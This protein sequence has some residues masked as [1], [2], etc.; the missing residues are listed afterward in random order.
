M[1]NIKRA[2]VTGA[3]GVVGTALVKELISRSIETLVLTRKDGRTE[4]IP[5]D[6]NVKIELCS[7]EEL[8][9][10]DIPNE[11]Y[12]VFFHLGWS[13]TYGKDRN[14]LAKQELNIKYTLDAVTLAAKLGCKVFVGAGSQAENGRLENGQKVSY[15][16]PEKPSS[17]YGKAK[18][19]A[20]KESRLLCTKLGIRHNWCR[21]LSVYGPCDAP[22]TMVMSTLIKMLKNE[23]CKFTSAEQQWDYIYNGDVAKALLTIAENG[24]DGSIY[25][26]GSGK[27]KLLKEY[28]LEMAEITKT[29]SELNFGAINYYPDQPMYLCADIDNLI[30]HTGYTPET[31]F[32]DGIKETIKYIKENNLV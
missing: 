8:S 22:Y 6:P 30:K 4:K 23:D 5:T 29:A 14:D 24:V 26:I 20:G 19:S 28:I 21:I 16:S 25:P 7:L 2:V 31:D 3:T 18:L 32:K 13:G 1:E 27:I 9:T 11:K 17:A 12:D 10:F 15:A